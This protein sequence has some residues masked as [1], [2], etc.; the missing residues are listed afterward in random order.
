MHRVPE[1]PVVAPV[2]VAAEGLDGH[3]LDGGHTQVDEVIEPVDDTG[4]V[5]GGGEGAHVEFVDHLAGEAAAGPR[6]IGPAVAVVRDPGQAVDAVRL[7][8]GTRIRPRAH[9]L[10][11]LQ[12]PVPVAH[13]G[14]RGQGLVR[15]PPTVVGV[16]H[17]V[18]GVID[19]ELEVVGVG[20]P[21]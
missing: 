6:V 18:C 8:H 9:P 11:V 2:A 10:P 7:L 21:D 20:C 1:H 4:E 3:E 13:P 12:H 15:C 17:G 19:D 16:P 5:A 14:F